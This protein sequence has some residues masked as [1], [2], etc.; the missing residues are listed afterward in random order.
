M[1]FILNK[2]N[3]WLRYWA[4]CRFLPISLVG[5]PRH[6]RGF[7][8]RLQV[9]SLLCLRH[10]LAYW[11]F[12]LRR[13]LW[14]FF[15]TIELHL[16]TQVLPLFY[17]KSFD[18]LLLCCLPRPKFF[19]WA[20]VNQIQGRNSVRQSFILWFWLRWQYRCESYSACPQK[21]ES[22]AARIPF[23]RFVRRWAQLCNF[24]LNFA[25]PS[26]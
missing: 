19:R 5:F 15:P 2:I 13:L 11:K 18:R 21:A 9:H 8:F 23:S 1:L 17:W 12:L 4:Y 25:A 26:F 22:F 14:A 6:T 16:K 7:F 20:L 3:S 10:P 24:H